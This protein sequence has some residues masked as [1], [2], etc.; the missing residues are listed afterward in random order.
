MTKPT[1]KILVYVKEHPGIRYRELV[2]LTGLSHRKMSFHL[3]ELKKSKLVKA[4]RLGYN[5]TRYYP[6]AVN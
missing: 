2:R 5:M 1:K 6:I 4:K 3:G